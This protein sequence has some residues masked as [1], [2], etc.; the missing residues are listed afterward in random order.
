[1]FHKGFRSGK[2]IEDWKEKSAGKQNID[3]NES[4]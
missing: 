4:T 1:M 3:K 2:E